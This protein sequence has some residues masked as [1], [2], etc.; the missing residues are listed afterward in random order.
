MVEP[1]TNNDPVIMA[2]PL[3]GKPTPAPDPEMYD[4]VK[5]NDAE[6]AWAAYDDVPCNEP[7]KPTVEVTEPEN[8]DEPDTVKEPFIL[9]LPL[10]A[11][12]PVIIVAPNKFVRVVVL[13]PKDN[14]VLDNDNTPAE[15]PKL[16]LLAPFGPKFI[17]VLET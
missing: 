12:E 17:L 10:T 16:K 13:L 6:L 3:N 4:A 15:L 1:D 14:V 8:T 9:T 11:K 7:V 5:A 2:D